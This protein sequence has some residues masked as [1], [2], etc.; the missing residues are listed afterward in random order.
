MTDPD[1][2]RE[3]G[4]EPPGEGAQEAPLHPSLE[5][6]GE[7]VAWSALGSLLG[8]PIVWGGVGMLADH[9]FG[10]GR[11]FLVIGIV[12]GTLTGLGIVYVRFGQDDG[13]HRS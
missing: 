9:V 8:G 1:Q 10:T 5:P 6:R 11:T 2:G 13:E 12:V 4:A 3:A 7:A